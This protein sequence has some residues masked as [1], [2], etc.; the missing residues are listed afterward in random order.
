MRFVPIKSVE[1][2][3]VLSLHRVRQGFVAAPTTQ[4]NQ[5]RGL[6]AEFG[7]VL[8]TGFCALRKQLLVLLGGVGDQ[9]PEVFRRLARHLH[10][11]L[12]ELDRQVGEFEEQIRQCRLAR[13]WSAA[14]GRAPAMRPVADHS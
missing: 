8:P 1:Q 13:H 14:A 9:V 5:I 3:T 10:E 6:L 7:L 11:H 2:Q 12:V 4:A